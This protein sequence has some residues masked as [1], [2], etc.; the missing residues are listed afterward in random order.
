MCRTRRERRNLTR[1][2]IS[3]KKEIL[4]HYFNP[5]HIVEG[6]LVEGKLDKGKVHCTCGIC[7]QKSSK[8]QTKRNS[9]SCNSKTLLSHRDL[10]NLEKMKEAEAIQ[11]EPYPLIPIILLRKNYIS[12]YGN[13]YHLVAKTFLENL[14]SSFGEDCF[15]YFI[16]FPYLI[17][18]SEESKML[19]NFEIE[20]SQKMLFALAKTQEDFHLLKNYEDVIKASLINFSAYIEDYLK[21]NNLEHKSCIWLK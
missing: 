10:K 21:K 19:S 1:R 15:P 16:D 6:K 14:K 9:Y 17:S 13:T 2:E 5:W 11:P 8:I 7:S 12:D 20:V 3:R 4:N 18:C